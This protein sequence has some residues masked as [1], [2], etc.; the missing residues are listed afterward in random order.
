MKDGRRYRKTNENGKEVKKMK[1][2]SLCSACE[3]CPVVKVDEE[4]VEIGEKSN[5]CVLT[6]D[7]WAVLKQKVLD[8]EI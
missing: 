7:E 2:V 5:L 1:V 8:G 4:R 3:A 6:K